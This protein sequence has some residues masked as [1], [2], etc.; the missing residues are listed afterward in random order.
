M[1]VTATSRPMARQVAVDIGLVAVVLLLIGFVPSLYVNDLNL[2]GL[3]VFAG[4]AVV[5]VL[6]RHRAL[7]VAVVLAAAAVA[8]MPQTGVALAVVAYTAGVHLADRRRMAWLLAAFVAV[9]AVM[10]P[11]GIALLELTL[12][13]WQV[14]AVA[15]TVVVCG[16]LPALV[17]VLVRQRQWL[18]T[19]RRAE[20]D[21]LEQAHRLAASEARLRER[22]R[23]AGEM[24]DVLGHR[25]SLI[26]LHA[27]GLE[28]AVADI[29]GEAREAAHLIRTTARQALEELRTV[30]GV[31]RAGDLADW[32]EALTGR[33]GARA[34][35]DALVAESRAAGVRVE[36]EWTGDSLAD[37]GE[38]VRRAVHRVIREALT[39]VHTHAPTASVVVRITRTAEQVLV[40]VRNGPHGPTDPPPRTTGGGGGLIGLH[41][42]VR[43]LGG[44]FRAERTAENGFEVHASIPLAGE[45]MAEPA[46]ERP[47]PPPTQAAVGLSEMWLA[48]L[49]VAG[50]A[51]VAA[52]QSFILQLAITLVQL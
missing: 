7:W 37:V 9:P 41:E 17:G 11:L 39:N 48:L 38:A 42:R 18:A 30:L 3:A 43:L 21:S 23:I 4:P 20:A 28:L 36:L 35:V 40:D 13:G 1:T 52:L 19:A 2:V 22:S 15:V 5:A 29:S 14:L 24:H 26:A 27:G 46:R 16:L 33:D 51:S 8:W 10:T 50:L 47:A 32:A 49:A 31:L 6:L 25:L 12:V 45:S 34:G 44:S